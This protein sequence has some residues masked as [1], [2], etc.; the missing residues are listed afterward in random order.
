MQRAKAPAEDTWNFQATDS[1]LI[2]LMRGCLP[3]RPSTRCSFAL[4]GQPLISIMTTQ[5]QCPKAH[6]ANNRLEKHLQ[7]A[8][9]EPE[10]EYPSMASQVP[11]LPNKQTNETIKE[12]V[13]KLGDSVSHLS[14]SET[15]TSPPT[16]RLLEVLPAHR[17][18]AP[19]SPAPSDVGHE[20][21]G[22]Q[23]ENTDIEDERQ[24]TV[25]GKPAPV[26]S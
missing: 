17:P 15:S 23:S 7:Y 9:P 3:A 12:T 20:D 8:E 10:K 25:N 4:V 5:T 13:A 1:L 18:A 14:P 6:E 2:V 19:S 24:I 16:L 21:E 11:E 22:Y 26:D